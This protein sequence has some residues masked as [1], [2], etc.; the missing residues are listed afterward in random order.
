MSIL[1]YLRWDLLSAQYIA[2]AILLT[3]AFGARRVAIVTVRAANMA[4]EQKRRWL[5]LARSVAVGTVFLGLL[6]IWGDELRSLALSVVAV[7]A[8]L[9]LATKELISCLTGAALRAGSNSF[10]IGDRIEVSN[11]RGEVIDHNLLTTTLL[12]IGP[13]Q[14]IHQRTGRRLVFPNSLLLSNAVVNET[15]HYDFVLHVFSVVIDSKYD[16]RSTEKV[17]LDAANLACKDYIDKAQSQMMEMGKREGL[18]SSSAAPKITIQVSKAEEIT[19]VVRLAVPI[20]RRG[21]IEQEVLRAF[22][23]HQSALSSS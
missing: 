3:F 22:A 1:E 15:F 11:L 17:L 5:V 20:G 13:G 18:D 21:I 7:L 14:N 12:E 8:A 2:S 9:V 10:R 19:L 23:D 16:W 4:P 6:I